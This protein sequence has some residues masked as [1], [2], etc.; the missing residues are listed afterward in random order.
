MIKRGFT[1]IEL[2]ITLAILGIILIPISNFFFTNYKEL[3]NVNR[4]LN[5]QYEGEK[6]VKKFTDV[7]IES[8]GIQEVKSGQTDLSNGINA[9]NVT[10]IV[11]MSTDDDGNYVYDIFEL[12]DGNLWYG[13]G[14]KN[15]TINKDGNLE[16]NEVSG[17]VIAKYI[18]S[19]SLIGEN[20]TKYEGM[21]HAYVVLIKLNLKDGNVTY[22]VKSKVYFRNK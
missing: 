19:I 4:R 3:N 20:I 21:K 22:S 5:L 11:L 2:I 12:E 17:S 9:D 15:D 10:R 6:A 1:L 16:Q 14:K 18:N 13:K 7:A 8:K